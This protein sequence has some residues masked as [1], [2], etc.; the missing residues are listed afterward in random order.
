MMCTKTSEDGDAATEPVPAAQSNPPTDRMQRR[1]EKKRRK[2]ELRQLAKDA[3][4]QTQTSGDSGATAAP[5]LTDQPQPV[6]NPKPLIV[7]DLNGILCHRRRAH[8]QQFNPNTIYRPSVGHVAN[9]EIIPRSDLNEFL[10]LLHDNFRLAIWTSAT[11]KTARELVRLLIPPEVR[12]RLVFVWH[13]SFCNLVDSKSGAAEASSAKTEGSGATQADGQRKR[14]KR[15]RTTSR[16]EKLCNADDTES[17][18]TQTLSHEDVTAVKCL[19]KVWSAHRSWDATNTII[20]DDSPEKC[21][22]RHGRN[23]LHPPPICGT[24]TRVDID[25]DEAN[26]RMQRDFFR[27][28]AEH[29]ALPTKD[30]MAFLDE[31]ADSYNMR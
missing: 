23:A 16:I 31:H 19:S 24:T 7:L 13:R 30:L 12:E 18:T 2:K 10:T 28:L 3:A 26:Q 22:D 20:L 11:R 25:D 9:T 6:L 29:W 4:V 14:R 17:T 8:T 1:R 5:P 15:R 21:P 27:L